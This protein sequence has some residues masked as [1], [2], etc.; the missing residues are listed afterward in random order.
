LKG[1]ASLIYYLGLPTSH[2]DIFWHPGN[3]ISD[4]ISDYARI[5]IAQ[6]TK[7]D[8]IKLLS[9]IGADGIGRGILGQH[10]LEI[11]L[12]V[13]NRRQMLEDVALDRQRSRR[14]PLPRLG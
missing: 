7:Q 13:E 12:L 3:Q 8:L 2:Q 1:K 5:K 11:T 14:R 10:V 9:F 4:E 6:F